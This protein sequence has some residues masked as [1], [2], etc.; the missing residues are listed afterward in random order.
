MP[1]RNSTGSR[2][3]RVANITDSTRAPPH[4]SSS[5]VDEARPHGE[6]ALD[7]RGR[8]NQVLLCPEHLDDPG[9]HLVEPAV[10]DV[11]VVITEATRWRGQ[12]EKQLQ[13]GVLTRP[14]RD[15]L[16]MRHITGCDLWIAAAR[17]PARQPT[18]TLARGR[19]RRIASGLRSRSSFPANQTATP[20]TRLQ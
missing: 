18:Q 15:V 17:F 19:L 14:L 13:S 5:P 8:R 10:I 16:R 6:T 11:I 4:Q 20:I 1:S 9:V 7:G 12:G 2:D 3:V